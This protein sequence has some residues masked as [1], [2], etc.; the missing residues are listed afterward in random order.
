VKLVRN[1]EI[2]VDQG[3]QAPALDS[4]EIFFARTAGIRVTHALVAQSH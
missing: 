2:G 4:G 1:G 3:A